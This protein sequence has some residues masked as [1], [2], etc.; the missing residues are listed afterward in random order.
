MILGR[1]ASE[2]SCRLYVHA[3]EAELIGIQ[4]GM[5]EGSRA[6]VRALVALGH[7]VVDVSVGGPAGIIG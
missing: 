2:S 4:R 3:G 1:W 6:R 5:A 7:H